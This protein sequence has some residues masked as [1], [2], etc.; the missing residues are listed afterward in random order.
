MS[1]RQ[2][3][4]KKIYKKCCRFSHI[5]PKKGQFSGGR[6]NNLCEC[7]NPEACGKENTIL[8]KDKMPSLKRSICNEWE[9]RMKWWQNKGS[10]IWNNSFL[11]QPIGYQWPAHLFEG[12]V[13]M[14]WTDKM[15]KEKEKENQGL[16][17]W[18]AW[19]HGFP[20]LMSTYH[21]QVLHQVKALGIPYLAQQQSLLTQTSKVTWLRS[22]ARKGKNL[23]WQPVGLVANPVFTTPA[24][25]L[26]GLCPLGNGNTQSLL[27]LL[28]YSRAPSAPSQLLD[29]WSW[30]PPT[31]LAKAHVAK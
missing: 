8:L 25:C 12:R 21:C 17:K 19:M 16:S 3:Q 4:I 7:W 23:G 27:A 18:A 14:S 26:C 6:W 29:P 13:F 15:R 9:I 30:L 24:V 10:V 28:L 22:R 5:G 2:I 20:V 31:A 11:A 1:K